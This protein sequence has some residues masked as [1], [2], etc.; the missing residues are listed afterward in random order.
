MIFQEEFVKFIE[1]EYG[2]LEE[3]DDL[4]KREVFLEIY[5]YLSVIMGKDFAY[6][7]QIFNIAPQQ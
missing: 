7:L 4:R 2:K 3:M 1:S 6:A 5:K